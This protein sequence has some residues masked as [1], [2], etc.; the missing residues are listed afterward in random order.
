MPTMTGD[1]AR[2]RFAAARSATLGTA[3]ADG[4]P[5]LVPVTFALAGESGDTVVFA[6]DHKP[7]RSQRLKRLANIA[8]N[9]AVTLLADAYDEDWER[10]WWARADGTARVMAPPEHS[11]ASAR[12]V[13]LL[14]SLV[15]KYREQYGPRPPR[16]PVVE[17]TV[18][19]WTGWR[20][21]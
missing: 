7:K 15:L 18:D 1:E 20:A 8:A 12:H 10:L 14:V 13:G 19:R 21:V 4:S 17:I 11:A 16:G 2:E 6:V 9:P 3:D 5:H